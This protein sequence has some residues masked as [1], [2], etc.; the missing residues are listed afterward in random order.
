MASQDPIK[1]LLI[2]KTVGYRHDS[3]IALTRALSDMAD[4]ALTDVGSDSSALISLL[5]EQDVIILGHNTG[6]FLNGA[7]LAAL[8]RFVSGDG[9]A[10]SVGK[11]VVGVHACTAGMKS[12]RW[13]AELLGASFAGHPDPQWGTVHMPPAPPS[14]SSSSSATHPILTSLLDPSPSRLTATSPPCPTHLLHPRESSSSS[15]KVFPWHDEWYNY[16]TSPDVPPRNA[17]VLVAVDSGSYK[18]AETTSERLQPLAWSHEVEG[19]RVFYTALG[20]FDAAY[21]D[22]WFMGMLRNAISWTARR[23]IP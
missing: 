18:G 13:Y 6:E 8:K 3:I 16:D 2:T 9:R 22:P 21:E 1:A 5:P 19:A 17:D 4:L 7:E 11:G 23:D 10:G 15:T 20:H 14:T 12:S